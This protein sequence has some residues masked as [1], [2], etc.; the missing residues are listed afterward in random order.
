MPR[1]NVRRLRPKEYKAV[2]AMLESDHDDVEELAKNVV[3]MLNRMRA[4]EPVWV[5][6]VRDGTG[7]VMYGPY[8]TAEEARGDDL[9]VGA[10]KAV[11]PEDIRVFSLVP[12]WGQPMQELD[13]REME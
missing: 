5:R 12:P 2:L 1:S 11:S 8:Q 3:R 9:S 7:Y 13:E 6:V 4:E 10:S